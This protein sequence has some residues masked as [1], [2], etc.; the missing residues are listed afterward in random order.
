MA[1]L[2]RIID[3]RLSLQFHPGQSRTWDSQ[4]RFVFMLAG[5]QSGKC[6]ALGTKVLLANGDYRPIETI[7][8]GDYVLS[9]GSDLKIR[10]NRVSASFST[11]IQPTYR[12][13]TS[14]GK[15]VV[16]TAEHPLYSPG[17]WLPAGKFHVGDFIGV[18]RQVGALGQESADLRSMRLLG[19]L[20]G[21]GGLTHTV[22]FFTNADLEILEDFDRCL[23]SGHYL[24]HASNYD[25]RVSSGGKRGGN[26]LLNG[27]FKNGSNAVIETCSLWGIW[28]KLAKHK[29]LPDFV[30]RLDNDSIAAVL[31]ALYSCD[32]T[33][34]KSKGIEIVLASEGMIDD[35]QSLLLRFGI[36]ARKSYKPAK[37]QSGVTHDSWRLVFTDTSQLVFWRDY[38][39]F[40]GPKNKALSD[41]IGL[42]RAHRPN[43]KD[44][45][46]NFPIQSCFDSMG[47]RG[48]KQ[49]WADQEA[50]NLLRRSR[51][52]NVS[53]SL[54]QSIAAKFG[55]GVDIA[56]SDI[57]WDTVASIEPLG[58]GPVWDITVEEGHN[59]I[60][61]DIFCHN[62]SFGPWWLW[63]E[64]Y[65]Y[66][67]Y[68]GRGSGDYLAVT[69]NF[70]LFKLK[71]LPEL[72]HVFER[73]LG[74][75][76][77]W[78][79]DKLIELRN[80]ETGEF[81]ADTSTDPM[82]G[83]II[84]RSAAA[85]GG[86]E[87]ATAKGAWLD[88]A[89]QDEFQIDSWEA[90]L[91][92]LALNEG[93]V[94]G[95]TTPYNLGWVKTQVY[96]EWAKGNRDFDVI[97]FASI[98]NPLFP[99]REFRRA[100][101][102]MPGWKFAMFYKGEFARPPGLI[103]G[104]YEED[105]HK[106]PPFPI[107]PHWPRYVGIDPGGTNLATVWVAENPS[108]KVFYVYRETLEGGVTTDDH[109]AKAK[110]R[111]AG[112]NVA[113]WVGGAQS[114]S[115][116][117]RDWVSRGISVKEPK[118]WEVWSGIDNIISLFRTKRLFLF[119]TCTGLRS[120][121]GTYSRVLD[122][123]TLEPTDEIKDKNIYHYLDALRYAGTRLSAPS[124]DS[125][126]SGS[127][128]NSNMWNLD[129]KAAV[130]PAEWWK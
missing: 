77:Y 5:T 127:D 46:P 59:F 48:H 9:L 23:P 34:D 20:L 90:I 13:T 49:P 40:V 125:D 129:N 110:E 126:D 50:Y 102:T 81:E 105:L 76:R 74:I 95:T 16:L 2:F 88:E 42:K 56:Y 22:P 83:R 89:G 6:V 54:A 36:F 4:A 121:L 33:V 96:D 120:Q 75:G 7:E 47:K 112:E 3:D 64:I 104:D 18:P 111:A 21:D 35:I 15:S 106:I 51:R 14:S 55:I 93:R 41:L 65:G 28:G 60:A 99:K 26:R 103:Y 124:W 8:A 92:R 44:V 1:D 73:V 37:D 91:R 12:I 29:R 71:L 63:R 114:E 113:V 84:L 119:D 117:R 38:I 57:Y 58:N 82:W 107:P 79:G 69:S 118:I 128:A 108:T 109:V 70:G 68:R 45:I 43:G 11:G 78:S 19:Y 52:E 94:L 86:L 80:P 32:G 72:R 24:V 27:R 17:G 87:S 130:R 31:C 39:G 25:Y 53:C 62:T 115:Q 101:R 10:P 98:L 116:F 97:Q 100:Q 123:K 66:S 67:G 122:K 85:G 61:E 30:F